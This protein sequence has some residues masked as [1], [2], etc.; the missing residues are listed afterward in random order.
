MYTYV[1]MYICVYTHT[2]TH[3]PHNF[4]MP[5]SVDG[6]LG[7]LY[8]LAT[9]DNAAINTGF[10]KCHPNVFTQRVPK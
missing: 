7:F 10:T 8:T 4:F 6:Y 3:T 9:V 2:H 5:S 1:H